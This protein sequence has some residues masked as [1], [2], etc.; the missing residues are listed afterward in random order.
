MSQGTIRSCQLRS[1]SQLRANSE[2]ARHAIAP[3]P[4][5]DAALGPVGWR[6]QLAAVL[7]VAA[8][9]ARALAVDTGDESLAV[10]ELAAALSSELDE[11]MTDSYIV[12]A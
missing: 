3:A 11:H 6:E 9:I 7:A 10:D 8:K 2:L 5:P 4:H 1:Q 12:A